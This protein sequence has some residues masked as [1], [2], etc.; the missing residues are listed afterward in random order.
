[1]ENTAGQNVFVRNLA[2]GS[3]MLENYPPA[4]ANGAINVTDQAVLSADGQTVAFFGFDSQFVSGATASH[5]GLFIRDRQSGTTQLITGP[6]STGFAGGLLPLSLAVSADGGM[7]AF[8][9]SDGR[10]TAN[11]FNESNDIFF[12]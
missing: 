9:S 1:D 2:T 4:G 7:V 8:V 10:L 3:I 11:D 5:E 6:Y 12:A